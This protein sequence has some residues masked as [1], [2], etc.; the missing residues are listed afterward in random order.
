MS[1][2]SMKTEGNKPDVNLSLKITDMAASRA[3][4]DAASMLYG[5]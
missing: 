1:M 4:G 2:V 5:G 3:G